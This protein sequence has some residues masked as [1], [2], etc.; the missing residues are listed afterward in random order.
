MMAGAAAL[1]V[2]ATAAAQ[3]PIQPIEPPQ[4]LD[5]GM[6]ELGKKLFFDPRLS[7]SGFISCHSCHNLTMGGGDNLPTS[8][9]H[10]WQ[11]GPINSPTVLNSSYNVAQFWDGRAADLAEQAGGPMDNPL[12][13]ASSHDVVLTVLATIPGYQAEFEEVFGDA[14]ITL[15]R[16]TAAIAEFEKTLV[17][18]NSRFDLWL[19]GDEN[20]ITEQEKE[21]YALFKQ[22]GCVGCH[23]GP[24]VG[25]TSFQKMGL[26]HPYETDNPAVGR[27]AV[28]GL[29]TDEFVFKVP[30]L[31]NVELT[32]PYFH[33]GAVDTLSEAVD[34][35]A[36]VQ[37]GQKLSTEENESIVAFLKTLTGEQPSFT[38]PLLPPSGPDTPRPQPFGN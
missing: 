10:N 18:P 25:G 22:K 28:T 13:M 21:G 11:Q 34:I 32:Y 3:E 29:E 12:E 23:N 36:W 17:T 16:T 30:T 4:G 33:D 6:V 31:R 9:G 24:A 15:E 38:L 19:K 14:D 26:I 27:A 1:L 35:M 2:V 20:A 7:K 8:V 5:A 37:A